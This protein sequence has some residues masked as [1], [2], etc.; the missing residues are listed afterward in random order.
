MSQKQARRRSPWV[1]LSLVTLVLLV[2]CSSATSSGT[3]ADSVT[4]GSS[5]EASAAGDESTPVAEVEPA[6]AEPSPTVTPEEESAPEPTEEPTAEAADQAEATAPEP[7]ATPPADGIFRVDDRPDRLRFV[8]DSWGTNWE[9]HTI[10]YEEILSGG[11]PRDGIPSIDNPQFI[12]PDE[13]AEWLVD[14]EPVIVVDLNGD[15]RAYPLQILIWHEI[16]NDTVGDQPVVVTFCPLCNS[17]IAFDRIVNGETFEFGTSGLLRNSDLVMYDRTTETLWQQ[18]TGEA[19]VGDLVGTQLTFLPSAIVSF[20]DFREAH[21]DGVVLSRDTGQ[22]RPYGQNPYAG[23]DTIGQNPFLFTGVIDGRLAAMERV[24]AVSLD[25]AD[26]AYPLSIL[27][28]VGVINDNLGSQDIVV[29]HKEGASSALGA[30]LIAAAED[31]GATGVFDPNLD[32]QKLTF[33]K[34]DGQIVDAETGSTWNILGQAVDGPLA[35]QELTPIIHGDH[36]WFSWAAF[37]PDTIIYEG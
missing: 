9:L 32:G 18:F 26:V 33:S 14:N 35:G 13:A 16:V 23:Y 15:A 27:A 34:Q 24:I 30:Q 8:T 2:A 12:T 5:T 25:E 29:F 31:V 28:E 3:T 36:F 37:R 11:P 21:P 4:D 1:I 17:A 10:D 6:T 22:Q 19:I 20:S 7:T